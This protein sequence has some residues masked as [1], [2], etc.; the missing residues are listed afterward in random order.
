MEPGQ[1]VINTEVGD[2][3]SRSVVGSGFHRSEY[4]SIQLTDTG[5]VLETGIMAGEKTT[6]GYPNRTHI[7]QAKIRS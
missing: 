3:E 1:T 4:N 5:Q 2:V 7:H 6:F